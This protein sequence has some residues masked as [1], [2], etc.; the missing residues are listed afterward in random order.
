MVEVAST[1]LLVVGERSPLGYRQFQVSFTQHVTSEAASDAR[2]VAVSDEPL[3]FFAAAVVILNKL[4][5]CVFHVVVSFGVVSVYPIQSNPRDT[6][7]QVLRQRKIAESLFSTSNPALSLVF[8]GVLIGMFF[9]PAGPCH[10][11]HARM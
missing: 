3:R 8:P 7:G 5:D 4:V 1:R 10:P 11:P 6:L 2:H 9:L